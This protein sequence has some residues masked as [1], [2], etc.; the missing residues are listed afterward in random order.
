MGMLLMTK[1]IGKRIAYLRKR[2]GLLQKDLANLA[3]IGCPQLSNIETGRNRP[4]ISKLALIANALGITLD[5]LMG[6]RED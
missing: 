3:G 2:Q 1:H 6:N 5:Q 4:S